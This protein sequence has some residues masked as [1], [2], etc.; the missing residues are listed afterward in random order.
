MATIKIKFPIGV[1]F[2]TER[3]VCIWLKESGVKYFYY[4]SLVSDPR[5]A[6]SPDDGKLIAT[7]SKEK[8]VDLKIKLESLS[9]PFEG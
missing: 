3:E 1:K 8:V 5:H 6:P 2:K 4:N 7:L 9:I